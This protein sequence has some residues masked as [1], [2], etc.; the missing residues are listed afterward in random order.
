MKLTNATEKALAVVTMLATQDRNKLISS[1]YIVE[2]LHIS[3]SYTKKLLR[4]LVVADI[5]TSIPGNQGGFRLEKDF[6]QITILDVVE[7]IE[8]KVVTYPGFG[9]LDYAFNEF[10]ESKES[11]EKVLLEAFAKADSLWR[12]ELSKCTIESIFNDAFG[13]RE[14]NVDWTSIQE[15]K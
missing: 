9:T 12:Q 11:G 10:P 13:S 15:E 1:G 5:I 3:D 7:A 14:L 8:G 4:K 6:D 2:R